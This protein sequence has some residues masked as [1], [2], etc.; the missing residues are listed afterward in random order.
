MRHSQNI[1]LIFY[2]FRGQIN[3]LI[4][5]VKNID[6][7]SVDPTNANKIFEKWDMFQT[8]LQ[9]RE[10]FQM[11]GSD[12]SGIWVINGKEHTKK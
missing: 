4:S 7:N 6:L 9:S 8:L 5:N 11:V 12:D 1:S 2:S 3:F 10:I